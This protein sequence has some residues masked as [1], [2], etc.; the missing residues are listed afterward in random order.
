MA[1]LVAVIVADRAETM[2]ARA[3]EAFDR[4]A[5]AVEL[6]LDAISEPEQAI[7]NL[8]A[9]LPSGRWIATCRTVAEGGLFRGP[10]EQRVARLL[11][12]GPAGEGFID[13]EFADW[14]RSPL[15]KHDIVQ[16]LA[17]F[18]SRSQAPPLILSHHDFVR[19]P[20]DLE[21]LVD[22]MCA[23]KE[24]AVIKVAWPAEDIF[25]NFEALDMMRSSSKDMI[26]IC[27][28]EAGLMSRV[29]VGKC[30]GFA[31]YCAMTSDEG[32]APGQPTL[33]EMRDLYGWDRMDES[34]H[35]YGV[36]G[37][38][39][40]HSIS[41]VLFNDAFAADRVPGVYLPLSVPPTY[42]DFARF[43]DECMAR[44]WLDVRGFSVTLPHKVHA[45]RYLGDNIDPPADVIGAVNTIRI[46]DGEM[47]GCNT[48]SSAAIDTLLA[49]LGCEWEAMKG[50]AVDVLGA[51]G[52]ARAVVGG[53]SECGCDVTVYNRSEDRARG[54]A[55][56]FACRVQPWANRSQTEGSILI[57]C[58]SMG[59]WPQ[60]NE[61]PMAAD[62][63]RSDV[64]V[65]DTVYR[66]RQTR[67]LQ[68]AARAGCR[69]IDGLG[70]FVHQ[71]CQQFEYWT[72]QS[73]DEGR[74]RSA[75]ERALGNDGE[76][77][78]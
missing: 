48:D 71:A 37:H 43:M 64:T 5:D 18:G 36:I 12:A 24:A 46:E 67:L 52:V 33:D 50:V 26:A 44:E 78:A 6:R 17:A 55:D 60:V 65:F 4:G 13:F 73:A 45:L 20:G 47:W 72:Q 29:L 41:P 58:T 38:P 51:G 57:N 49:G 15:A 19:R 11:S 34:T 22:R 2:R 76:A 69:T 39:V 59:M 42:D 70:M 32:T 68:D 61:S 75:A 25:S 14:E 35:V 21:S 3:L 31:T 8:A 54:L 30:G 74:M 1:L 16:H 53:L 23:V 28:G 9:L 62:A 27:M 40:E 66:P 10:V 63:L 77:E 56:A 7:A